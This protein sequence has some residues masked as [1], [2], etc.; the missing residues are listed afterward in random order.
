MMWTICNACKILIHQFIYNLLFILCKLELDK[1]WAPL[2]GH[3]TTC[4]CNLTKRSENEGDLHKCYSIVGSRGD[5]E[6]TRTHVEDTVHRRPK[7]QLLSYHKKKIIMVA[8]FLILMM[9]IIC[10]GCLDNNP[11]IIIKIW[12]HGWSP[13]H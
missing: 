2:W 6:A 9:F 3:S 7:M 5:P 4:N 1:L 12:Q 11:T 10:C 13:N 8:L